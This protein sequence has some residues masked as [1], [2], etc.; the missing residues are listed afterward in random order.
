LQ[1][2]QEQTAHMPMEK[3]LD[4]NLEE[5]RLIKDESCDGMQYSPRVLIGRLRAPYIALILNDQDGQGHVH[6]LLWNVPARE[7]IPR[8]LPKVAELLT[9]IAGLQGRNSFGEIGYSS[10]CPPRGER[11]RYRIRIFGLNGPLD[12]RPGASGR[13]LERALEG[14]ILQYGELIVNY[15]RPLPP[16]PITQ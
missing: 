12:L 10:V 9:P 15:D 11:H 16:A 7:D 2:I 5:G 6:W 4:V 8:N 1:R 13:D 14:H 3:G